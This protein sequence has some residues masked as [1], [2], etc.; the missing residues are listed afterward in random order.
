MK[1]PL[2]MMIIIVFWTAWLACSADLVHSTA[3]G[4]YWNNPETWAG[5]SIPTSFDD[6]MLHGPVWPA[7]ESICQNLTISGGGVLQHGSDSY[8]SGKLIVNGDLVNYGSINRWASA[9][10]L[11]VVCYGNIHSGG[12]VNNCILT[13]AGIQDQTLYCP[14]TSFHPLSITDTNSD[15]AVIMQ[16]DLYLSGVN[17][18]W[19]GSTLH[20]NTGETRHITLIHCTLSNVVIAGGNGASIINPNTNAD[21]YLDNVSADELVLVGTIKIWSTCTIGYLINQSVLTSPMYGT[22]NLNVTER[23]DNFGTIANGGGGALN[24]HLGGSFYNHGVYNAALLELVAPGPHNLWQAEAGASVW[25]T[26]ITSTAGYGESQLLSN[27]NFSRAFVNLGGNSLKMYDGESAYGLY[28]NEGYVKNTVIDGLPTSYIGMNGG[29]CHVENI[30]ATH[31]TFNG[32]LRILGANNNIGSLVNNGTLTGPYP[33]PHLYISERLENHGT[34]NNSGGGYLNVHLGGS[35]YNYGAYNAGL[36]EL[37]APG[38]HNLWQAETGASIWTSIT[39]TAGYG[40]SRLLSNINFSRA[41]IDLGGN[42]LIMHDGENGYGLYFNQ[43]YLKNAVIDAHPASYIGMNGGDCYTGSI[44]ANRMTF[45]GHLALRGDSNSIENLINNG[46][47]YG[48]T[49]LNVAN[50]L[51]NYGTIGNAAGGTMNIH[52]GGSFYNHAAFHVSLLELTAPG[53]HYLWQAE[54]GA[55]TYGTSITSAAGNG[56]CRLLCSIYF[57]RALINLGGNSLIMHDGEN[58][59]GLTF[60]NEG[61]LKNAVID[62]YPASYI[63]MPHGTYMEGITANQMTFNSAEFNGSNNSVD[64][65]VNTGGIGNYPGEASLYVSERLENYGSLVSV[66]FKIYVQ[67]DLYNYNVM[68]NTTFISGT[69]DQFVRNAGWIHGSRFALISELGPSQWYLNGVLYNSN[70]VETY[71]VD[72]TIQGVWQPYDGSVFGRQITVG[73]LPAPATPAPVFLEKVAGGLVLKWAQVPGAA[74]YR[75]YSSTDPM[76][77]FT[78]HTSTVYDADPSDGWVYLNITPAD[79]R[80]FYRVSARN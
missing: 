20:L 46:Q 61:Y 23:L 18:N 16:S 7:T 1:T 66:H 2:V 73:D 17:S 22:S 12:S 30:T 65:M 77:N 26:S 47:L 53:P 49:H 41:L 25:G 27:F 55:S 9:G 43:G 42:S 76:A 63:T 50:R 70:F 14:G 32:N 40:E 52:L 79:S 67:G 36:L 15:S 5:G 72:P 29:D 54:T 28:F 71:Y 75:V 4:G 34:M 8:L 51:D 39:S 58:G 74:C 21:S 11:E 13:L 38:P 19:G 60:S 62:A 37:I 44:T 59:F 33:S 6:V 10:T 48:A 57:S 3:N 31:I 35:F 78:I 80:R 64:Y 56:E 45:N 68:S 24:I 69:T